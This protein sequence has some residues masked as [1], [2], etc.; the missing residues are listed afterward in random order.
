MATREDIELAVDSQV[1]VAVRID[2]PGGLL[3]EPAHAHLALRIACFE[4]TGEL[5]V[6]AVVE[7]LV[8][9]REQATG[10]EEGVGLP[11]PVAEELLLDPPAALVELEGGVVGSEVVPLKVEV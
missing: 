5:L 4:Q 2:L 7:S 9:H 10:P 3:G 1:G 6:A 8:C 11:P